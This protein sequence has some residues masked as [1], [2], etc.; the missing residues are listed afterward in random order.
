MKADISKVPEYI[1]SHSVRKKNGNS[2]V[3]YS[4]KCDI[5]E[6]G[7]YGIGIILYLNFL[8]KMAIVF[9]V[10]AIVSIPALVSNCIGNGVYILI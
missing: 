9:S 5:E 6:F 2:R 7:Q 1:D 3:K 10:M 4:W 8:K